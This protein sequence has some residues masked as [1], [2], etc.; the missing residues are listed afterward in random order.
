MDNKKEPRVWVS[1]AGLP[2]LISP[3]TMGC[4][5]SLCQ[6]LGYSPGWNASPPP[7]VLTTSAR[8]HETKWGF[9][10]LL[11]AEDCEGNTAGSVSAPSTRLCCG[12]S[13][14]GDM[15]VPRSEGA[16]LT[17]NASFLCCVRG[18]LCERAGTRMWGHCWW[19][20]GGQHM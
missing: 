17:S 13:K 16:S 1:C 14:K 5:P 4:V 11:G 19:G 7:H 6:A 18:V 3:H 2:T 15:V 20:P 8:G 9:Q 10:S 12:F